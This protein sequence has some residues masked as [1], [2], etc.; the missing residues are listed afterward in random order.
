M[1]PLAMAWTEADLIAVER[2][3]ATGARSISYTDPEGG[4]NSVT[5]YSLN[6]LYLLR[7]RMR[8]ELGLSPPGTG[9]KTVLIGDTGLH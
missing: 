6:E 9:G 5:H 7:D 3:I 2:A 8:K 4:G 1:H